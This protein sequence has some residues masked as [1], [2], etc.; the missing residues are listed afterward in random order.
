MYLFEVIC[1]DRKIILKK[2]LTDKVRESLNCV[3]LYQYAAK[4]CKHGDETSG[5]I[6][7]RLILYQRRRLSSG[8]LSALLLFITFCLQEYYKS[9]KKLIEKIARCYM[10]RKLAT[11]NLNITGRICEFWWRLICRLC[12]KQEKGG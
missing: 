11:E 5:Y 2:D 12:L 7:I 10:F 8:L 4:F 1:W 6:K 9:T 3:C